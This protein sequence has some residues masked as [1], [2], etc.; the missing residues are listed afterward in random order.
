[1]E[2]G[3]RVGS[4]VVREPMFE[5]V[6]DVS[7]PVTPPGPQGGFEYV[8]IFLLALVSGYVLRQICSSSVAAFSSYG[9]TIAFPR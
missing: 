2:G 3:E 8:C 5:A 4:A 7:D 9:A 6:G 1:M